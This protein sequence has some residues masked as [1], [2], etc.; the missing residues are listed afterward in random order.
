[1]RRVLVGLFL[2]IVVVS[3]IGCGGG[4]GGPV[5]GPVRIALEDFSQFLQA[6][7]SDGL[8]PPKR[9]AEFM[10]LEP[11]APVAGEYLHNG[12]LVY[13][14]GAG[15]VDGGESIIAHQKDAGASGGW[16]LLENGKVLYMS[17]EEFAAAPK[18]SS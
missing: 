12:E 3:T 7:P 5:D 14:W 9:M 18:A 8:K 1:M 13:F 15:L 16:V 4:S 6:L 17:A 11:M 2:S 10:P